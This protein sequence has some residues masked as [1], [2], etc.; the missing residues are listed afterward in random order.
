MKQFVQYTLAATLVA[1]A[2]ASS[3]HHHHLHA[4]KHA[5][6]Q[7]EKRAP[8]VVTEYVVGATETVYQLG[9]KVLKADEAKAGLKDGNYIIVG[10]STPV[11]T[12]PPPPPKAATSK[13]LGAQFI[14]SKTTSS[15]PPPTTT[16][17]PAPSS[18]KAAQA[19]EDVSGA[20]GLDADFPSGKIKCTEFPA[21][22]GAIPLDWLD[23]K[24]WSGLQIV[25]GYTSASVSISEIHTGIGGDAGSG[26]A[27]GTMCSYACPPGYQKSQFPSAQGNKGQSI[28][29]LFCN[30][31]G[32]LEL[33]RPGS[34]KLCEAGLGGVTIQNDLDELVCTCRTEYPGTENMVIPTCAQPG[35][36]VAVCNPDQNN[37]YI[38]DGMATS[39]QYYVN[40]KGFAEKDA[41]VWN[42]P[43]SPKGAGN[44]SP[45]ILG[46][47]KA[48]DSITYISIFQNSP[49]STA[50]LDFNIEIKGD[51]NSKCFYINGKWSGG[52]QGCTVSNIPP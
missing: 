40:P 17:T 10:E 11:Y 3:H 22:Y 35:G 49:T 18:P 2:A 30:S 14:E 13:D 38:W 46:V 21:K 51:V 23:L 4:K 33:T 7:V 20:T 34:K 31:N 44:W 19:K 1:G 39:A 5:G 41:C 28:G 45:V 48:A 47:G 50:K 16:P 25:P 36:S 42:S 15:P 27:P 43:L 32:Y 24:G 9:N 12:P 6:S 37:Y 26:C 52:G 8:D 29:G